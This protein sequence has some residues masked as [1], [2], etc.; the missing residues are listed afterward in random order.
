MC[1]DFSGRFDRHPSPFLTQIMQCGGKAEL[2]WRNFGFDGDFGHFQSDQIVGQQCPPDLLADGFGGSAT[3]GKFTAKKLLL[4]F[5]I[6]GF[7]APAFLVLMD[8][9]LGRIGL[10][11]HQGCQ[12]D[13]FFAMSRGR[14][15]RPGL[16]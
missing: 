15:D 4:E 8:D 1:W 6:A 13:A 10:G 3:Q 5:A 9:V 2:S 11:I 7:D 12:Q 16:P 14:L